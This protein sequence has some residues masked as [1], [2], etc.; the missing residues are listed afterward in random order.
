MKASYEDTSKKQE[1]GIDEI[2]KEIR[3]PYVLTSPRGKRQPNQHG[4]QSPKRIKTPP[5]EESLEQKQKTTFDWKN[6]VKGNHLMG[7][8]KDSWFKLG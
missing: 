3:E 7:Q 5:P 6:A 4:N 2:I 8:M 1:K